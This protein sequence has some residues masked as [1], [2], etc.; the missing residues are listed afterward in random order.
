MR[1]SVFL[2]SPGCHYISASEFLKRPHVTS[3]LA[4]AAYAIIRLLIMLQNK[5]LAEAMADW[6]PW[7]LPLCNFWL[8]KLKLRTSTPLKYENQNLGM[9]QEKEMVALIQLETNIYPGMSQSRIW[10]CTCPSALWSRHMHTSTDTMQCEWRRPQVLTNPLQCTNEY[11]VRKAH[12]CTYHFCWIG[13]LLF[14]SDWHN[15]S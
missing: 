12:L 10:G 2:A 4:D 1:W 9:A 6:A 8:T 11:C 7:F 15:T 13:E 14:T 3:T 5:T